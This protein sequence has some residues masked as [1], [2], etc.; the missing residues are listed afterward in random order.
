M[1]GSLIMPVAIITTEILH[2][3][4]HANELTFMPLANNTVRKKIREIC[5]VTPEQ[6]LERIKKKPH[7]CNST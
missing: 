3:T 4:K 1:S 6:L 7:I 5:D 2:G